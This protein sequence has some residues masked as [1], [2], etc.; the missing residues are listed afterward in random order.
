M[1]LLQKQ[2]DMSLTIY[3]QAFE[4]AAGQKELELMCLYEIGRLGET[5]LYE[6]GRSGETPFV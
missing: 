5:P 3:R 4:A 2:T 6:I 1:Y